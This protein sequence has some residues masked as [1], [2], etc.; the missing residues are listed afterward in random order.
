MFV[1]LPPMGIGILAGMFGL[2]Q[3]MRA[4][5]YQRAI[6]NLYTETERRT[7]DTGAERKWL[8]KV[9]AIGAA[10]G[11][12]MD[13]IAYAAAGPLARMGQRLGSA[14]G[15]FACRNGSSPL[16]V[17]LSLWG[18]GSLFGGGVAFVVLAAGT[19]AAVCGVIR[20]AELSAKL[21]RTLANHI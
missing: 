7:T 8:M 17:A 2:R 21:D 12:A 6:Y 16:R 10:A 1:L 18:H 13:L 9:W 15:V 20:R 19:A 4:A 11:I 5:A 14:A 3:M